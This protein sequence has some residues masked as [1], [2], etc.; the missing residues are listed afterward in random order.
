[1]SRQQRGRTAN[2]SGAAAEDAA[3][4]H[5]ESRGGRVLARRWKGPE[6]ELDL[7]VLLDGVLVFVEVKQRSGRVYDSP[8]SPA[9]WRRLEATA[10]RYMMGQGNETG[11]TPYCRFDLAMAGPEGSIEVIEN[12]R[13]FDEQ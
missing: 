8:V 7:V 6:G 5:Y 2:R 9:Q 11:A 12:A 4:R 3:A 10:E 13:S 1:M